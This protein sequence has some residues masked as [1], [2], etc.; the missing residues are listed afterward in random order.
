MPEVWVYE[1]PDPNAFATGPSKNNSMVAVSTGL[2]QNLKEDEV[3]AVLAHEMG[4]HVLEHTERAKLQLMLNQ[5]LSSTVGEAPQDMKQIDLERQADLFAADLMTRAGFDLREAR[6]LLGWFQALQSQ[7][8]EELRRSHPTNRE[9][10]E[11]LDR[12]IQELEE[13][14]KRGEQATLY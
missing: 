1:S 3:K 13:K 12:I 4:H 2:L 5:F 10:L 6:R 11:A 7:S 9:R 8:S 14:R